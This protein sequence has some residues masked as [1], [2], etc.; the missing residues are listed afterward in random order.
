MWT[1]TLVFTHV[2]TYH[3]QT[4]VFVYSM[5]DYGD[6]TD[7]W[8]STTAKYLSTGSG[9]E[10][11]EHGPFYCVQ[12]YSHFWCLMRRQELP[13]MFMKCLKQFMHHLRLMAVLLQAE[14]YSQL[15]Y[16][17]G[18][19]VIGELITNIQQCHLPILISLQQLT[20]QF[21]DFLE[22]C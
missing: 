2:G 22:T 9:L 5:K 6:F 4:Q 13:N 20:T 19:I 10:H 21:M 12:V 3:T 7:V 15:Y 1:N 8:Y 17:T 14:P 11:V 16:L 18:L